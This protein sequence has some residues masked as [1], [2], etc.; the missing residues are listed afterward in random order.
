MRRRPDLTELIL[1]AA[2]VLTT[3]VMVVAGFLALTGDLPGA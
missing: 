2:L 3:A 1:I